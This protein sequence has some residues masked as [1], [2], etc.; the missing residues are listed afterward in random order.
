MT[1]TKSFQLSSHCIAISALTYGDAHKPIILAV[2]GW[3]DNAASFTLLAKLLEN[4][5]IIAL[6]L[7]GHGLT[8]LPQNPKSL[9]IHFYVDVIAEIVDQLDQQ[10]IILMGHSMGGAVASVYA[11]QNP[12]KVSKLIL[13]DVLGPLSSDNLA[14]HPTIETNAK[15]MQ[16]AA[17]YASSKIYPSFENMVAIRMKANHLTYTQA[18]ELTKRG[19]RE[20]DEGF[21]WCYDPFVA[22]SSAFY[23]SES[24][25]LNL[26]S[27]IECP[28]LIVAGTEGIFKGREFYQC[29]LEVIKNHHIEF[30]DG[31]HHIH[32]EKADAV[33]DIIQDFL[34]KQPD[35]S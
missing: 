12:E 10:S 9:D 1:N 35:A 21:Q 18:L 16:T 29:R 13:I 2:H 20:T 3:L 30:I 8:P 25:V 31:H 6:D 19:V 14:T 26:L 34:K 15:K 11:S 27:K 23:Y 32:L 22:Q 17:I 33:F 5:Y 24:E 4:F 7:P 28:V